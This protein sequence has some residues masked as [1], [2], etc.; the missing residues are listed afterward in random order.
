MRFLVFHFRILG[1]PSDT[2]DSWHF[3]VQDVSTLMFF[4]YTS[5]PAIPHKHPP[6][7]AWAR[8]PWP[9]G[10]GVSQGYGP[11]CARSS[12][13]LLAADPLPK[14]PLFFS[15]FGGKHACRLGINLHPGREHNRHPCG[16]TPV[17][18]RGSVC[19]S[20]SARCAAVSGRA[21][22]RRAPQTPIRVAHGEPLLRRSG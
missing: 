7:S 4:Q 8:S 21:P 19:W 11:S 5:S 15:F 1:Y 18:G 2:I 16:T 22:A 17:G 12:P 13:G 9:H 20:S 6:G 3:S 10:H 14:Y